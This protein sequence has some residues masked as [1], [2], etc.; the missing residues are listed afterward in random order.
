VQKD[1]SINAANKS[2]HSLTFRGAHL[3]LSVLQKK[4]SAAYYC[5]VSHFMVILK[6]EAN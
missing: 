6:Q 1:T 5:D 2:E 3:A 4:Q